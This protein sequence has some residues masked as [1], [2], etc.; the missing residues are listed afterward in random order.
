[1]AS[2]PPINSKLISLNSKKP[3]QHFGHSTIAASQIYTSL[4]PTFKF[5]INDHQAPLPAHTV[6][7]IDLIRLCFHPSTILSTPIY[8]Q[9]RP[10]IGIKTLTRGVIEKPSLTGR[11]LEFVP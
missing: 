11:I 6:S 10:Q 7:K 3:S 8:H 4:R 9:P 1:M 2:A 5:D